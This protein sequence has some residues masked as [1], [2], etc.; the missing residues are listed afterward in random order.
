MVSGENLYAFTGVKWYGLVYH[1][2][3]DS[4]TV[5]FQIYRKA[6][7][8]SRSCSADFTRGLCGACTTRGTGWDGT[9]RMEGL[10]GPDID[11]SLCDRILIVEC[12][13]ICLPEELRHSPELN[14]IGSHAVHA[15]VEAPFGC[16]PS[17]VPNCYDYDYSWV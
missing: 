7:G 15:I 13:R 4:R 9:V 8:Q 16:Y 6:R 17:A 1:S 11:Q 3:P 12:E 10:I 5:I 2:Q 14:Q